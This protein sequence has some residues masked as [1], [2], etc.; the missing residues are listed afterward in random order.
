VV[1]IF[2]GDRVALRVVVVVAEVLSQMTEV[3]AAEVVV[4]QKLH[5]TRFY[6]RDGHF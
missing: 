2:P 1:A 3:G 4:Q 6:K 5:S